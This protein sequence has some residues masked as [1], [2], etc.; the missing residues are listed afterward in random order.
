M[1]SK[2]DVPESRRNPKKPLPREARLPKLFSAILTVQ[3]P[4]MFYHEINYISIML[5]LNQLL[6]VN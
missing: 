2:F 6:T 4:I 1:S 3:K 5:R